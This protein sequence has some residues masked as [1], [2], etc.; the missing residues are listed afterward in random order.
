M[1]CPHLLFPRIYRTALRHGIPHLHDIDTVNAHYHFLWNRLGQHGLRDEYPVIGMY[2]ADPVGMRSMYAHELTALYHREVTSAMVKNLFIRLQYGGGFDG[3]LKDNNLKPSI[4]ED[5]Q[6]PFP[7]QL[8]GPLIRELQSCRRRHMTLY[9]V[10]YDMLRSKYGDWK[11]QVKLQCYLNMHEERQVLEDL[12]A[13]VVAHGGVVI[14]T[15]MTVALC[16]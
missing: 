2:V 3:W 5:L 10:L 6:V 13:C 14:A 9:P 16:L 11:A 4:E 1:A 8:L 15:S 7:E 12:Q